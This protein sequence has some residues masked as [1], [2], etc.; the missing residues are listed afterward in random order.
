MTIYVASQKAPAAVGIPGGVPGMPWIDPT[1]YAV[2]VNAG[3][4]GKI[5]HTALEQSKSTGIKV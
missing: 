4:A 1:T 3:L 5:L 2:A